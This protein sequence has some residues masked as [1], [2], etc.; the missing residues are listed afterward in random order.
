MEE[1]RELEQEI[2]NLMDNLGGD[3]K[4]YA[5]EMRDASRTVSEMYSPPRVTRAAKMQPSLGILPG[6]ALDLN[7]C[8]HRGMPWDF[9]N[10]DQRKAAWAKVLEE[11]P[12]LII[13]TPMCTVF[14][15]IRNLSNMKR[16]P[17]VVAAEMR[18]AI[19]H[20]TFCCD[21]YRHQVQEGRFFLHEHPQA[22]TSWETPVVN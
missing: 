12:M 16:D 20:L 5:K 11:K 15:A 18:R 6:F 9:D 21:L 3:K 1:I 17:R 22:A 10:E 14:S 7:T 8:D 13:G 19:K 4:K 2:M